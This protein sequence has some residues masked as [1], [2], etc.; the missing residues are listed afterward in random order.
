M[1]PSSSAIDRLENMMFPPTDSRHKVIYARIGV[2]VTEEHDVTSLSRWLSSYRRPDVE[3]E[4]RV[5]TDS[6]H[7]WPALYSPVHR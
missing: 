5:V 7:P 1:F 4:I 3:S 2:V 6:V